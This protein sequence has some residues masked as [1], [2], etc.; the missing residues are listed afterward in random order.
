MAPT[1]S[2]IVIDV[3]KTT[4]LGRVRARANPNIGHIDTVKRHTGGI[5]GVDKTTQVI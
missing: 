2:T 5:P 3:P 1:N 4:D